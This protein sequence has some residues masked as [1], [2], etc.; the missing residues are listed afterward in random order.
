[1][2]AIGALLLVVGAMVPWASSNSIYFDVT[3]QSNDG[4]GTGLSAWRASAISASTGDGSF[5]NGHLVAWYAH[6]GFVLT[7]VLLIALAVLATVLRGGP[8]RWPLFLV[9]LLLDLWMF[10]SI[11]GSAAGPTLEMAGALCCL[12]AVVAAGNGSVN[13][14]PDVHS[15]SP[16]RQQPYGPSAYTPQPYYPA[17]PGYQ[18]PTGY[19]QPAGYAPPTGFE[20]PPGYPPDVFGSSSRRP[21]GDS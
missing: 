19:A 10:N 4:L 8:A 2:T 7:P 14:P 17:P 1:M 9:A 12:A 18:P 21:Q 16:Y 15:S 13:P 5:I 6:V 11:Y 20:P 3:D